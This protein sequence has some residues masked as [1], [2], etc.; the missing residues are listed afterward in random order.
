MGGRGSAT[1][2]SHFG[3]TRVEGKKSGLM[4]GFGS[5]RRIARY[6]LVVG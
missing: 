2:V 4:D 6:D 1:P 3:Q 5:L